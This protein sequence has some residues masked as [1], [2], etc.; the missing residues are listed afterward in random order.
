MPNDFSKHTPRRRIRAIFSPTGYGNSLRLLV[1]VAELLRDGKS[2]LYISPDLASQE[3]FERLNV[4]GIG[5]ALPI[6]ILNTLESADI[7]EAIDRASYSD[8]VLDAIACLYN[9]QHLDIDGLLDII[10]QPI[11][12]TMGVQCNRSV[13]PKARDVSSPLLPYLTEAIVL[14]D[15]RGDTVLERPVDTVTG[16]PGAASTIWR[17]VQAGGSVRMQTADEE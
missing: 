1:D 11:N 3:V 5:G 8:V 14:T 4:L 7:K 2:V 12:V 17:I 16:Q 6:T 9:D 15:K 13:D 10:P